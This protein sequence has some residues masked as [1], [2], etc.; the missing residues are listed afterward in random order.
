MARRLRCRIPRDYAFVASLGHDRG[1]GDTHD[2]GGRRGARAARARRRARGARAR[3]LLRRRGRSPRCSARASERPPCRSSAGARSR[4]TIRRSCRRARG[5]SGTSSASRR[6]PARPSSRARPTPRR[7]SGSARISACSSTRRRR[8]TS[9]PAGRALD[10]EQLA[11]LGIDDGAALLTASPRATRGGR[12]GGRLPAV[13]RLPRAQATDQIRKRLA[14]GPAYGTFRRETERVRLRLLLVRVQGGL[15]PPLRGVLEPGQDPVLAGRR[16]RPR[17]R[18]PRGLPVL[19][20]GGPAAD[21]PAPERRHVQPRPPQSRADR[22]ARAGDGPLRHRQPPLPGA[23]PH[24]ARRGAR[25]PPARR[26]C[27]A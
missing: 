17:D 24:R 6:R 1:P 14:V 10:A 8:S 9:S 20:H 21:R 3:P 25:R 2:P 13:R 22:R 11:A 5:W 27:A 15:P 12:G 23:R 19:G 4:P 7:R 18:S 16:R 26:T